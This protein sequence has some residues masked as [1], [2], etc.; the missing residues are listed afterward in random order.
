MPDPFVA[1]LGRISGPLLAPNLFRNGIDLNFDNSLLFL[2]VGDKLVGINTETPTDTLTVN[3]TFFSKFGISDY[4]TVD[5]LL[6]Q[7]NSSISSLNGPINISPSSEDPKTLIDNLQTRD[8]LN[9]SQIVINNNTIETVD[10]INLIVAVGEDKDILLQSNTTITE[11]DSNEP[12]LSVIGN[13]SLDGDLSTTSNIIIGDEPVDVIIVNA[14]LTQDINPGIDTDL[15]NNLGLS[16]G[17]PGKRWGN[18]YIDDWTKINNFIIDNALINNQLLLDGITNTIQPSTPDTD[19]I[20]SSGTNII[21]LND[22]SIEDSDIRNTIDTPLR[23]ESTGIGYWK[24]TSNTAFVIPSGTT[25]ERPPLPEVGDTRWNPDLAQLEC[26][27]GTIY[28]NSIGPGIQITVDN[29]EDLGHIYTL[30]L[31]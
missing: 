24:I 8:F 31:G 14:D 2:N 3:Q 16:L 21:R 7:T 9:N 22:I 12:A 6:F 23:L 10:N 19:L 20:V 30:M 1:Q 25:E 5:N 17:S 26:F 29:M 11:T 27:D 15:E 18:V 13:I 28:L 4:I